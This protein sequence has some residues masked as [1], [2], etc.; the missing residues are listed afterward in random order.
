MDAHHLSLLGRLGKMVDRYARYGTKQLAVAA[1]RIQRGRFNNVGNI[2]I[3]L[4]RSTMTK[5]L[6]TLLSP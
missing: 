6:A 3:F 4:S 5:D 1:T 2:A